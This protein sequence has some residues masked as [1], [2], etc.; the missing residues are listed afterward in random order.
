MEAVEG[1]EEVSGLVGAGPGSPH[2]APYVPW[3][4]P[5]VASR[6]LLDRVRDSPR[7]ARRVLNTMTSPGRGRGRGRGEAEEIFVVNMQRLGG[8]SG[9]GVVTWTQAGKVDSW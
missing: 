9:V 4:S 8:D 2:P 1:V 3:R 7:A 6:R 5:A